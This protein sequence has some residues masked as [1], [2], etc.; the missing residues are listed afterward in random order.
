MT[1]TVW[2]LDVDGVLNANKPGWGGPPRKVTVAGF[3]IRWA[4]ALIDRIRALHRGG[5]VEVRWSST[6]CGEPAD[7]AVLARLLRLDLEV[8]FGDRSQS[9][10]WAEKKADAALAVLA[11]GHRLIWTGDDEAGIARDFYPELAEAERDGRA[12]LIAPRSSRG[13]QPE[14]LDAVEAFAAAPQPDAAG[15]STIDAG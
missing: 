15:A 13:L 7:L 10:T 4:P 6:R 1:Q 14:H 11:D 9:K 12:L 2:L 5:T 3:V 8:V